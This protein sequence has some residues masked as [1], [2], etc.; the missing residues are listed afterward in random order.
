MKKELK[1]KMILLEDIK[2]LIVTA[3]SKV[4]KTVE[5]QR[6]IYYWEIGQRIFKEV[7]AEE[8]RVE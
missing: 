8:E 1:N 5:N 6:A 7:Q 2:T 3:Q 4:V